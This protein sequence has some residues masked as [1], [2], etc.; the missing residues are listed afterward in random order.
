MAFQLISRW[1]NFGSLVK[2]EK[3]EVEEEVGYNLDYQLMEAREEW[4]DA[5]EYFNSVEDPGL[6]DHA[7]YL[8]EAT[9]SKYQYLLKKKK[10][11]VNEG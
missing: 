8:I 11:K 6:I 1:F 7:I 9:E 10:E 3:E 2:E 4:Q 5:R